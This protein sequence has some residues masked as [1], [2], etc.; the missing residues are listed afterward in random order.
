MPW[1]FSDKN[2]GAVLAAKCTAYSP[3]CTNQDRIYLTS[4]SFAPSLTTYVQSTLDRAKI[5]PTGRKDPPVHDDLEARIADHR[6][7]REART[8]LAQHTGLRSLVHRQPKISD[9]EGIR[10]LH[11]KISE[12][13]AAG[14]S[15]E[16][17]T[18]RHDLAKLLT[19][20]AKVAR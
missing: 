4:A 8:F 6:A 16:A 9:L 2:E 18:V 7:I 3:V 1:L 11:D 17:A 10:D 15:L 19:V 13:Y 12:R 5:I 14:T 20:Y